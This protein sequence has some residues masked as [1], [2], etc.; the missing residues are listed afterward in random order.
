MR[1]KQEKAA[2]NANN[3]QAVAMLKVLVR[4]TNNLSEMAWTL[5]N[6]GFTTSRRGGFTAKQVSILKTDINLNE[7]EDFRE[8]D[9]MDS[10]DWPIP[11]AFLQRMGSEGWR[12]TIKIEESDRVF[13]YLKAK[14][15]YPKA[16]NIRVV[17]RLKPNYHLWFQE[18]E[19]NLIRE[20]LN[21]IFFFALLKRLLFENTYLVVLRIHWLCLDCRENRNEIESQ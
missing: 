14:V 9:W 15:E 1:T 11:D 6:E 2:N 17:K 3:R 10:S 21:A 4:E 8:T 16:K 18:I 13:V 7:T 12:E 20:W 19:V 5:N